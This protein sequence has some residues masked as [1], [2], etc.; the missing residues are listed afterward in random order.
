MSSEDLTLSADQVRGFPLSTVSAAIS[1]ALVGFGGSVAIVLQAA[2]AVGANP[3]QTTSWVVALCIGIAAT[4]LYLSWK[5]RMPIITAW[6]TPGAA[7]IALGATGIGVNDAVGAFIVAALMVVATAVIRPLGRL[8][9]RIPKTVA[10]AMLA[11]VLFRFCVEIV[12]TLPAL[13]YL[14]LPLVVAFFVIQLWSVNLAVPIVLVLGMGIAAASGL[15]DET[16]CQLA[17]SMPMVIPPAFEISAAIG[18][19]LPLYIVTMASQNLAGLAVLKADGFSPSVRSCLGSTGLISLLTAPFGGH[20]VCLSAITASICTG[21]AC[22]PSP[23]SRWRAGPVYALCYLLFAGFA[24][25]L[26]EFLLALPAALITTFVGLALFGP[27]VGSLK[28][29]LAGDAPDTK[30]AAVTFLV[31]AS[32]LSILGI[33]AAFWSLIAGLFIVFLTSSYNKLTSTPPG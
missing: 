7:V 14:V 13:P 9:E 18:L 19:A 11:G 32:G 26:V 28:V 16:C 25:T 20:A 29:A 24:E 12:V 21:P 30:A 27:L 4:S 10:A 23:A 33:G 8:M 15:I 3:D 1:A 2:R 31:A 5:L 17:A 22:H 6:S